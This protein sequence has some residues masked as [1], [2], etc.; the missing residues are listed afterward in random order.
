MA[1]Y[2]KGTVYFIRPVGMDGPVKIGFTR[3]PVARLDQ[4]NK[5]VPWELEIAATVGG[6]L[7]TELRFHTLLE[8]HR[9]RGEWFHGSPDVLA[10]VASVAAGTFDLDSLPTA[11]RAQSFYSHEVQRLWRERA[12]AKAR[13]K[14]LRASMPDDLR[15]KYD[16]LGR[17]DVAAC[18]AALA[19]LN[20][21]AEA[22]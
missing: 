17:L 1:P 3:S 20:A 22:A 16:R 10:V 14:P 12:D 8:A 18:A 13:L 9:M 15:L 21:F 19:E 4:I 5:W 11:R 7:K 2:S 6:T